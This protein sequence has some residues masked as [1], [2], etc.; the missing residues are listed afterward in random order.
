MLAGAA[1]D[2]QHFWGGGKK[3]L[4]TP[5]SCKPLVISCACA[6]CCRAAPSCAYFAIAW[7]TYD[8]YSLGGQQNSAFNT[9]LHWFGQNRACFAHVG[10]QERLPPL[11]MARPCGWVACYPDSA[12]RLNIPAISTSSLQ[13]LQRHNAGNIMSPRQ[14]QGFFEPGQCL[15]R[16]QSTRSSGL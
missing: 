15:R 8:S 14:T 13:Q 3:I 11:V 4:R 1:R 6:V 5:R 16:H 7:S 10:Q 12:S 2:C 9:R